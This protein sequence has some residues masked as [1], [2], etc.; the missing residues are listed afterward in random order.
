MLEQ[1]FNCVAVP[2]PASF[3][4][5]VESA[6]NYLPTPTIVTQAESH[7]ALDWS[8]QWT[9][10]PDDPDDDDDEQDTHTQSY[11]PID[12]CQAVIM[13]L[14][15]ALGEHIPRAFID[16]ETA[17]FLPFSSVLPDPYA[18]RTVALDQFATALL[19][20]LRRP[21]SGQPTHRVTHMAQRLAELEN[22]FSSILL[23]CSVL[24]WPWIREAYTERTPCS[25]EH[26]DVDDTGVYEIDSRTLLFLFGE[27]PFVTGLY[28]RARAELEYDDNLSVD[29]VK[30]LLLVART[31]YRKDLKR[32][33]RKITPHMLTLCLK[34]IRNLSLLDRR[35][36]PDLYS[37][38]TAAKQI[39]GDT[40]A[41]HVVESARDY[42]YT[43]PIGFERVT[44]GLNRARL[45]DGEVVRL[46]N[47]LPGPPLVWRS[48][49]LQRRPERR[50]QKQWQ[51]RWDPR[52]QCSWPPEDELIEDFRS[53]VIDRAK[54]IMGAD[55]VRTE[56][57]TTSVKDGIDIRDTLRN[58]HTG[59]IFVKVLPPGR[60]NLDCVVMLFDSPAD[61]RDYPWRSTWYAE[62]DKESTLSFFASDFRKEMVGP[63]IGLASYGGA[64]FLFPSISIVNVWNDPELDFTETLEERLLAAAFLR[65]T[66]RHIA[67][68][69][70]LPPGPGWRRL[71]RRF[72]KKLVH[73]PLAQFSESTVQ[74]LRM[75]HVLNGRQVRSFASHFI[76]KA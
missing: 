32:R 40:Y 70:T 1:S 21:P 67:L 17:S 53:H 19:P 42:S 66:R 55:L 3:Q 54:A 64:M 5:D 61:P 13:A 48:L 60:S 27:L 34:Y 46:V 28:E 33:A 22:K 73:V 11:V 31:R 52:A 56:K 24:D 72:G 10:D 14:R 12:P 39:C 59:E 20:A 9:S 8:N 74:Q 37:I 44:L 62:H 65:S 68:L 45:P 2:L 49:N 50:E 7:T 38:A 76:R 58:W 41:L 43:E 75:V 26:D 35:M 51:M 16:L 63:G 4:L 29:G 23:V 57:F 18:L 47:R 15:I 71:A 6:I 30:E 36:T 25:V 69:S